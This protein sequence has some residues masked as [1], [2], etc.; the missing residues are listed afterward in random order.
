MTLLSIL[1]SSW[2]SRILAKFVLTVEQGEEVYRLVRVSHP[3]VCSAPGKDRIWFTHQFCIDRD[4]DTIS[5]PLTSPALYPTLTSTQT[6]DI[7]RK[8]NHRLISLMN[9]DT[10][11]LSKILANCMQQNIERVIHQ[12]Q[13]RFI[14]GMQGWLNTQNQWYTLQY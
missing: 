4:I 3:Q 2:S 10:K 11:I 7:R 5:P 1:C 12:G 13:V 9:V 14:T 8:G 6:R